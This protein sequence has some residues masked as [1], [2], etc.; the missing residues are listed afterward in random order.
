MTRALGD[1]VSRGHAS[2]TFDVVCPLSLRYGTE[3]ASTRPGQS[4]GSRSMSNT[5]RACVCKPQQRVVLTTAQGSNN[6]IGNY[7]QCRKF[8]GEHVFLT[9]DKLYVIHREL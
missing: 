3:N 4:A 7:Q 9:I 8:V 2:R 6:Y 5:Y 1:V